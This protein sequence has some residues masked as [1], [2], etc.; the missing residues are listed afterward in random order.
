MGSVVLIKY[1][2]EEIQPFLPFYSLDTA[3]FL[4]RDAALR[5]HLG[6]REQP[7]TVS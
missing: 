3:F 2:S 1:L 7:S 4:S 6:C 5:H